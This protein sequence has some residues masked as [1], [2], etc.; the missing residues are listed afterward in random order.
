MEQHQDK[1]K[2]QSVRIPL[3]DYQTQSD[4]PACY[5]GNLKS[6]EWFAHFKI[7][8]RIV[9]K[10]AASRETAV[11]HKKKAIPL[12]ECACFERPGL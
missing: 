1:S 6:D 2:I 8:I 11:L 5:Y 3:Q 12:L 9:L 7:N 10:T 4:D